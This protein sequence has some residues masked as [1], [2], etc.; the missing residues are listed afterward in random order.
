MANFSDYSIWLEEKEKE[1]ET[2]G[3]P[4]PPNLMEIISITA[5]VAAAAATEVQWRGAYLNVRPPQFAISIY[6]RHKVQSFANISP[7]KQ[8]EEEEAGGRQSKKKK[9]EKAGRL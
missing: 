5:P 3:T 6:Y 7:T 2:S 4:V 1:R 8:E 9:K